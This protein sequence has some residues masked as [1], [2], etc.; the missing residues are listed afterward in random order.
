MKLAGKAI[1]IML[2]HKKLQVSAA[3]FNN[4]SRLCMYY[5]TIF[6]NGIAGRGEP[7]TPFNFN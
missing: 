2:S 1:L 7:V 5:H 6:Y 3:G 4:A